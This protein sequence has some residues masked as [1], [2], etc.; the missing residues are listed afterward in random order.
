MKVALVHDWLIH[1]RGGE[2]VLDAIA[3]LYPDATI[4]TLFSDKTKL[5]PNLQRH[6]IKNS[7]LQY[8]PGIKRYYRWLLPLLPLAIRSLKIEAA[9]LV[10]SSS[11]CVAK[12]IRIPEKAC[13]IC[14]CH[15]PMRYLWGFQDVYFNR[16]PL[17]VRFLIRAVLDPLRAWDRRTN[18]K[19]DLFIANSEYIRKRIKDVYNRESVVVH[20]PLDTVL[21]KPGG[22]RENY[23]LAVS[24]FVPY[25]RL[26]V[27]IEAFNALDRKLVVIGSGPLESHYRKL[28]QSAQISF[29]G[30]VSDQELRDAYA[31]AR[32]LIFPA[33]E[34]FGIVPLEAQ[35]CGTPVI[36][37]GRGG[38]LETVR[39]GVFFD[40][41]T[42]EAVREAV[43]RFEREHYV[44]EEVSRKVQRFGR[45]QFLENMRAA[46]AK[47]AP[48]CAAS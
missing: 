31:C 18:A 43:A 38:A 27:V 26:D 8:L 20:P 39:S 2:K 21:Y 3:E 40:A 37:F 46:V 16:Y 47:S 41:Q 45:G 13:H 11:H 17:P 1:M 32:A 9:D 14:Y 48:S 36:A 30:S 7:F 5:S 23:F 25:K 44:S 34:D 12:G 28:S 15:T 22:A 33:E 4:Y 6:R 35:A 10:I 24:H 19:V 42:P 29:R